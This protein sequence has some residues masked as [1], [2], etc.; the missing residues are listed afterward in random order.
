MK[1]SIVI[2]V[3][4]AS[5][6][7]K[8]CLESILESLGDIEGEILAVDN[9]STDESVEILEK[10]AKT[11]AQIKVLSCKIILRMNLSKFSRSSRRLTRKLKC[12]PV[13]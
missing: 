2:P 11:N 1:I 4:N 7:L 10:F 6:Y 5:K 3:Y 12:F 13:K 9:N 8:R